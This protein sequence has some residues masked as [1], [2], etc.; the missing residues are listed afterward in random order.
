VGVLT[1]W[2]FCSKK[3]LSELMSIELPVYDI[4]IDVAK[5][6]ISCNSNMYNV[7]PKCGNRNCLYECDES[8]V[9]PVEETDEVRERIKNNVFCDAVLSVILAHAVAGI[10]V[11]DPLYLEGV[12]TAFNSI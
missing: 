1:H 4:Y 8:H 10:N 3:G 7:C 2:F 9:D 12:E 11:A 6:T 5:K